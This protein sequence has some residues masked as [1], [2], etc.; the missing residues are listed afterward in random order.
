[1]F[2]VTSP[3]WRQDTFGT[4]FYKVTGYNEKDLKIR[5]DDQETLETE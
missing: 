3:P 5:S 1:V 2:K 4:A